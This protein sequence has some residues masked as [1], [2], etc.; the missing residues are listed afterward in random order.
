MKSCI[1]NLVFMIFTL[2]IL[3]CSTVPK[4]PVSDHCNGSR[5]FNPD[6]TGRN[7]FW[8]FV[9]MIATTHQS[10]WPKFV[11][12]LPSNYHATNVQADQVAV[13]FINHATVLIQMKGFTLLTDPVWSK[14]VSP[15]TWAG[16]KRHREP[17]LALE[18]LPKIDCVLISHNH[19][20]I[21]WIWQR[22]KN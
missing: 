13:T 5:F 2:Q 17:G 1:R 9:K 15:F 4:Y 21:I 6:K 10:K 12:N 7:T 16:P 3:G 18:N 20:G 14:R 19:Y 11:D 22:S 8:T